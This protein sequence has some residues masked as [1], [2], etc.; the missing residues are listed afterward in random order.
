M[1]AQVFV[2][3]FKEGL[4]ARLAHDL[5]LSVTSFEIRLE[6]GRVRAT[7]DASSL[8]VD[9]VAQR[10][11]VDRSVLSNGDKAD[12]EETIRKELLEIAEH[13]RIELKGSLKRDPTGSA[14]EG[15]LHLHGHSQGLSIPLR[16]VSERIVGEVELVPSKFAIPQYKAFMGAIALQDRVVVRVELFEELAKLEAIANSGEAAVFE[17]A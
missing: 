7:F 8:R 17:P 1:R 12:I 10:G 9:G 3:T 16:L 5:R 6:A 11:K 4:F 2:F 14:V 13:P 15:E